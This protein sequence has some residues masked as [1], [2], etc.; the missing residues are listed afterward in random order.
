MFEKYTASLQVAGKPV[1]IHLWDT[2]GGTGGDEGAVVPPTLPPGHFRVSHMRGHALE[3]CPH[4]VT[5]GEGGVNPQPSPQM[6]LPLS[7]A[8]V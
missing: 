2:A 6:S 8:G 1:R 7:Q 5:V 4:A 3:G